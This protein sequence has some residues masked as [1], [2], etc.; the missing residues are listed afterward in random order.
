MDLE[1]EIQALKTKIAF[2]EKMINEIAVPI[3]PSIVD[4]TILVP[5]SG[6]TTQ[7]RLEN[8]RNRILDYLGE[9]RDINCTVCDFT[10]VGTDQIQDLD[11][12]IL[13]HE[14]S[15]LD[16]S[17]KLMGVRPIFVGFNYLLVKEIVHAGVHV[18]I[19]TY[20]NFKTAL[21]TLLDKAEKSV[22]SLP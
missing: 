4:N 7:D 12:N 2:Y 19:E 1:N 22:H 10:G 8:I 13:A 15:Q 5:I 18:H 11:Y 6:Y 3:I 21:A 9:H 20:V 14:I 17:L 16:S